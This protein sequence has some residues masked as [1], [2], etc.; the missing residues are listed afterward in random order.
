MHGGDAAQGS[1]LPNCSGS[2]TYQLAG[3]DTARRQ[4]PVVQRSCLS[5]SCL[6]IAHLRIG[7]HSTMRH[8]HAI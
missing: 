2:N 5:V 4:V 1:K 3:K 8:Q 6:I 7:L